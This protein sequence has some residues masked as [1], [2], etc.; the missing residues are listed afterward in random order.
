[1]DKRRTHYQVLGVS[2]NFTSK[3]LRSAFRRLARMHHP[4]RSKASDAADRFIEIVNAYEVLNDPDRRESYERLLADELWQVAVRPG[5]AAEPARSESSWSSAQSRPGTATQ[6]LVRLAA[7]LRK[8]ATSRPN[9]L[10]A[11]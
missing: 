8:A 1:M 6:N 10:H 7:L 2:A 11:R 5:S 9:G 3:E 4:D